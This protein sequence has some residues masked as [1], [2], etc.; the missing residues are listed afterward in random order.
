MRLNVGDFGGS[1][2]RQKTL[3]KSAGDGAGMAREMQRVGAARGKTHTPFANASRI[4]TAVQGQGARDRL[5]TAHTYCTA[6][7][8]I[9]PGALSHVLRSDVMRFSCKAARE[10]S[11]TR[12]K[13]K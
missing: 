9:R 4:E 3:E 1:F 8:Q 10:P 7:T 12:T 13:R 5:L 11:L 2:E 6:A